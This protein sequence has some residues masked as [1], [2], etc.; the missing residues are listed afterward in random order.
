[1]AQIIASIL[2]NS[3]EDFKNQLKL[4]KESVDMVQI[5]LADGKFVPNT[6]WDYKNP[7]DA[8][9][10]IDINFE[11]HLMVEN[12]I[13]VLK[14]WE[15][16]N[17]LKRI[18]VHYES[19][20]N[21]TEEIKIL[22]EKNKE[23]GI[24]LNPE[25]PINSIDNILEEIDVV[26]FMGV[27]PGFQGQNFLPETLDK[28]KEFKNKKTK[29]IVEVDGAVNK[30]TAIDIAKAGADILCPGSAIF[31]N[32]MHPKENIDTIKNILKNFA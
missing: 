12:P 27:N 28:I 9:K 10:Y 22:K 25:T 17:Y 29:H 5:D 20:K 26:M 14:D 8:Q 23:L 4:S 2:V 1:M 31:G 30:E 11:L 15:K 24:V 32:D 7:I 3:E 6:T 21:P 16:N 13:D 18:L 19:L